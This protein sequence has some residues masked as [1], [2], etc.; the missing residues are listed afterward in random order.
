TVDIE[1]DSLKFEKDIEFS[2]RVVP[3]SWIES[4][5]KGDFKYVKV[6]GDLE[7]GFKGKLFTFP[8]NE[9]RTTQQD[10]EGL[11]KKFESKWGSFTAKAP[12]GKLEP[13]KVSVK[14]EGFVP[15]GTAG[16]GGKFLAF[17]VSIG[18][19]LEL[20]EL[21]S[22][23]VELALLK[24]E[25]NENT[26]EWSGGVGE[27][28]LSS[29]TSFLALECKIRDDT[30]KVMGAVKGSMTIKPLV[31]FKPNWKTIVE[32]LLK[33]TLEETEIEGLEITGEEV[34]IAVVSQPDL[35]L[36]A[37]PVVIV[38]EFV[39]TEMDLADVRKLNA[40]WGD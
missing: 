20:G 37:L 32:E 23:E 27:V 22:F 16:K 4:W 34:L 35:L 25:K 28:E 40:F 30:D 24:F 5:G 19:E 7:V 17:D 31:K 14:P 26:G 1:W 15:K 13:V 2:K 21:Q 36:F 10:V 38:Y 12:E 3:S 6:E 29:Q 11:V 18:F 33:E 39:K 8:G 9:G